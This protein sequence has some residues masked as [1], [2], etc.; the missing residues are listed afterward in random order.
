MRLLSNILLGIDCVIQILILM[1][2][3]FSVIVS[4]LSEIELITLAAPLIPIGIYQ[5]GI[6]NTLH[7]IIFRRIEKKRLVYVC[8][9][10]FTLFIASTE[11]LIIIFYGWGQALACFSA[12]LSLQ[13]ASDYFNKLQEK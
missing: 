6:S 11:I 9:S 12:F 3:P 5:F 1:F 7:I 2:I 8:L 13:G 4:I 10:A